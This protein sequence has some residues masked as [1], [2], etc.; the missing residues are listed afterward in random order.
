[1]RCNL[2]LLLKLTFFYKVFSCYKTRFFLTR[3][4]ITIIIVK[5]F[6]YITRLRTGGGALRA[7]APRGLNGGKD[8]G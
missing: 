1:M 6:Y 8:V 2:I 4:L 7:K 5:H 3:V